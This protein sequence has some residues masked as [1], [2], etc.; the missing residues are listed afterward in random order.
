VTK[1][2]P[3]R[4]PKPKRPAKIPRVSMPPG[5]TVIPEIDAVQ[6]A[7]IG[8]AVVEWS[9]L[10]ASLDDLIWTLTGLSFEDG[11]VLT[12]RA[13]A[14]T[15]ISMLH[16]FAPR[17]LDDPALTAIE[18]ALVLANSLRD[19]RNFIMHGSWGTIM[20]MNEP[21][22]LSLRA[23]S[24]PGEV[25]SESFSRDRMV[26]IIKDMMKARQVFVDTMNAHPTSPYKSDSLDS[27]D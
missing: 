1:G 14:K 8:R 18:E 11:R 27:R 19:D 10:E 13:D 20:P 2:V 12:S 6:E 15:K 26:G 17:Y 16:V 9:R 7:L 5:Q 21:T 3:P 24:D 22:A 25:T 23:V 4:R